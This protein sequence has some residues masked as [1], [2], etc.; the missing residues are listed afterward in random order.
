MLA[1]KPNCQSCDAD[2]P[3]DS[4]AAFICTFECTYCASCA[5][6]KL[7]GACPACDGNL[8]PRPVRPAVK[9]T[10]YP[11]QVARAGLH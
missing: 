6:G 7:A 10:Q 9:L 1:L 5:L 2:I 8:T 4:A 11:G 3:H